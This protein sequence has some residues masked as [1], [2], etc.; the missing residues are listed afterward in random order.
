MLAWCPGCRTVRAVKT[1][2]VP[3]VPGRAVEKKLASDRTWGTIRERNLKSSRP[4]DV[5][6]VID[7]ALE[8]NPKTRQA[9]ET[10]RVKEAEAVQSSA[11]LYPQ[12]RTTME[13]DYQ[14]S[15]YNRHVVNADRSGYGPG[16]SADWLI[17]DFGGRS[18]G[19][20]K[21]RQLLVEANFE[22]NKII[23]DVLL[24]AMTA[25]YAMKT[26]IAMM[27]AREADVADSLKSLED[28]RERLDAGLVSE[29]DMLQAE[30]AYKRALYLLEAGKSD[31]NS[32]KADLAFELGV[33][34]DTLIELS[35]EEDEDLPD[36]KEKDVTFLIEQALIKR[37]DVAA[38]KAGLIAK[39]AEVARV[40][41]DLLPSIKAGGSASA[42]WYSYYG[43][44]K[45]APDSYK[46]NYLYGAYLK[47]E[48]DIFDGFRNFYRK[49]AA[50]REFAAEQQKLIEIQL[51]A[52]REV[53]DR[54]FIFAAA[55][56][57]HEYSRTFLETAE[58][59]YELAAEGYR[60]GLKNIIDLLSAQSQLSDARS[61]FIQSK[62]D[63]FSGAAR[64]LHAV[65]S[66]T[67]GPEARE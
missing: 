43:N 36:I 3:W 54:Y 53:W 65:G 20:E 21:A 58:R 1:P 61:K 13:V 2:L 30:S 42:E 14:R 49:K 41:S 56:K 27:K 52:S 11:G 46:D 22:F 40:T 28:S 62:E 31:L 32:A 57:Q 60:S 50:E 55:G 5:G 35:E 34:A 12:F 19:I 16:A 24:D 4:L 17:F 39:K 33:P 51:N 63:L 45:D 59:S 48:W 18:A 66:L 15:V 9:W 38:A 64:L 26:S 23:Q 47:A 37:P 8:N 25:Y 10:A 29:L 67:A 44:L 6:D 7:I